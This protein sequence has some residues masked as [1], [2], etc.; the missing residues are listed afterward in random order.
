MEHLAE[1]A[2]LLSALLAVNSEA[3]PALTAAMSD[4]LF[5]RLKRWHRVRL[6]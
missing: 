6:S 3:W 1:A 2:E 5:G 4:E